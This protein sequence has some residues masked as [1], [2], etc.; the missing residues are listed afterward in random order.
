[1]VGAAGEMGDQLPDI[2]HL[3]RI[4][5]SGGQCAVEE[6]QHGLPLVDDRKHEAKLCAAK[7]PGT[8]MLKRLFR[9]GAGLLDLCAQEIDRD[10]RGLAAEP[11][12]ARAGPV[13]R[14]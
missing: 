1:M 4:R 14:S 2:A 12:C 3:F 5:L 10:E 8:D 7:Q 6:A 11:A 13:E 9:P